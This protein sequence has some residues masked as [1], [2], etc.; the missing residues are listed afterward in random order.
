MEQQQPISSSETKDVCYS[1]NKVLGENLNK[2][3]EADNCEVDNKKIV[4]ELRKVKRQNLITHCLLGVLILLTIG[5]QV[6]EVSL[7]L[8]VKDGMRHPFRSLGSIVKGMLN[9]GGPKKTSV[10]DEGK[11]SSSCSTK[12]MLIGGASSLPGLKIPELPHMELPTLN[13]SNE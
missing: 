13:S 6:S 8:M 11:H 4:E 12:E 7:F 10:E 3:G 5:W 2:V 9:G 1:A